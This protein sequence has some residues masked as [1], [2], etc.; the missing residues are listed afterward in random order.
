MTVGSALVPGVRQDIRVQRGP[1]EPGGNERILL[2]GYRSSTA[3]A[4]FDLVPQPMVS[5]DDAI[6]LFG[7]GAQLTLMVRGGFAVGPVARNDQVRGSLP[8]IWAMA[9]PPPVEVLDAA[10]Q[11]T[12][13]WTG[14]A[15]ANAQIPVEVGNERAVLQVLTDDTADE[16]AAKADILF[17]GLQRNL[18]ITSSSALAVTTL[19]ARDKGEYANELFVWA[20]VRRAPGVGVTIVRAVDG[21]GIVDLTAALL[22][23]EGADWA[24]VALPQQ[25]TAT[26]D[27]IKPHIEKTWDQDTQRRRRVYTPHGGLL[28]VAATDAQAIQDWRACLVSMERRPGV[29]LPWDP[30]QS[31][32]SFSWEASAVMAVRME[33][34]AI[35]WNFNQHDVPV[36]GRPEDTLPGAEYDIGHN[37]GV[38]II[39]DNRIT[40]PITTATTDQTGVTNAPDLSLLPLEIPRTVRAIAAE[41]AI[42]LA[43]FSQ[44]ESRND[45]T[46]RINI[47]SATFSVFSEAAGR[48]WIQPVSDAD[49]TVTFVT[50]GGSVVA[51]VSVIYMVIVG[52]D[53]VRVEHLVQ[54]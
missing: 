23:S 40:D 28:T 1:S 18:P 38:S 25:D 7:E 43:G 53:I 37:A 4:G 39:L 9:S 16:I 19:D 30:S 34:Q 36:R 46:T 13:T 5:A 6:D 52:L 50:E 29:G 47:Q 48:G 49:I 22:A 20:D 3:S 26:R 42:K 21:V 12:A 17:Q 54:V 10:A 32:R 35:G 44:A 2:I 24:G 14:P 27:A 11:W 33:S 8:N 15:T 51:V 41:L 45:N 31:S